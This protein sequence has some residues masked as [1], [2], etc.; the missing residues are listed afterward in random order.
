MHRVPPR[1][2]TA[3]LT[4]PLL[5]APAAGAPPAAPSGR[6]ALEPAPGAGVRAADVP[7]GAGTTALETDPYAMVGATWSSGDPVVEV[8]TTPGGAWRVLP[9]LVDGPTPGEGEGRAGLTAT[10]LVWV[11]PSQ[12]VDV[13][14][15]GA[16]RGL[17]LALIEPGDD[18]PGAAA[19]A[20]RRTSVA[21]EP[22]R[23]PK[24]AMR[25]RKAWGA[26]PSWRN[27]RPRYNKRL[28]QVHVHHT[29][30][31]NG[32]ARQDVP[33]IIRGM[34]RYHTHNLGWFDLGYNFLVDRFGRAWV[35]RSGGPGRLVRGAHTLG[36]NKTSVG[37]A[38]I[39]TFEQ[40]TP[41]KVT[42]KMVARLASWKLDKRG[43]DAIGKVR[44]R[45]TGSDKYADGERVR[46]PVIDG[47]RDTND[48]A[49][50]GQR[51]YQRLPGIRRVA[52]ARI[53]RFDP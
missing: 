31:G 28:Q 20:A 49:C 33:G 18:E 29:A 11:G 36:F 38:V 40:R 30:T 23:A 9:R 44:V 42:R 43:R 39:G 4:L 46:L 10:E 14:V 45:S 7:L 27:G 25:S 32:Y 22:D 50:P 35:G 3:V 8:R 15:T 52:Q 16:A 21:A 5:A 24:P 1:V 51:L 12:D 19:P 2:L 13:R 34:Y 17:E 48:T 37:V 6:V 41:R 53:D 26:D 47:H